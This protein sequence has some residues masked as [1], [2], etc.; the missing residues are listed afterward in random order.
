MLCGAC[1]CHK[2]AENN[3]EPPVHKGKVSENKGR[4]KRTSSYRTNKRHNKGNAGMEL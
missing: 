2:E 1:G 3:R 4:E